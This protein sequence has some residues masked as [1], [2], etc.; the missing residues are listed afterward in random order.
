MALTYTPIAT[1]T[2]S[3]S[4]TASYTFSSIPSTY[5][6]LVLICV[7][8]TTQGLQL[9]FNGDTGTNYSGTG[10]FGNGTA[11]SSS[12]DT[13]KAY[14]AID[15]GGGAANAYIPYIVNINNYA[16]TT[17][18]KT[19]LARFNATTT[20]MGARVCLW[21]STSAIN[22]IK[23]YPYSGNLTDQT[24]FTLYGITAA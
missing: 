7:G 17:T 16:N 21:R 3:G 2:I 24:T 11:A 22:S 10:L 20:Y 23:V 4:G 6:D 9:Q 19:V 12:N 5:T 13:N 1:T 15:G 8:S 14:L 18:Y